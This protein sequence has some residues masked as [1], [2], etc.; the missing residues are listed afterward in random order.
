MESKNKT[1]KQTHK[2]NIL[3]NREQIGGYHRKGW[4]MEDIGEDGK[5]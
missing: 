1:S 5:S 4:G 3:I 2:T